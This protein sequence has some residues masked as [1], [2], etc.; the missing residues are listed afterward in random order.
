LL[1][2]DS[3]P[4]SEHDEFIRLFSR[5]QR[6]VYA[7]IATVLVNPADVEEVLQETSIVLWTKFDT[8]RRDE[9]FVK[10]AC[11]VAH[12]QILRFFR[13]QKRKPLPLEEST[14]EILLADRAE[15]EDELSDRRGAL[16]ECL[17]KLGS[18]DRKVI[19]ACYAPG[20][21]FKDAAAELGRSAGALYHSLGRIRRALYECVNRRIAA[22]SRP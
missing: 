3:V 16:A 21:T 8:F 1:N 18:K 10:W 6:Q 19:A 22:E 2:P 5:H 9:S 4:N 20:G 15:M 13:Q 11:G 17:K 12:L 14:L 7:Y